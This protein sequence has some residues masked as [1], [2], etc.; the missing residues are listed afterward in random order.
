MRSLVVT[1]FLAALIVPALLPFLA[2]AQAPTSSNDALT[3]AQELF[4]NADFRS[5]AVAFQKIIATKPSAEAYSGL[6]RSL[7]KADDV[8]AADEGSQKALAALPESALTHIARGDVYFR[9]G[10]VPEAEAEYKTALNLDD[11]SSRGWL[12]QGK[13]DSIYSRR[14]KSKAA[15]TRAHELD[16]TDGDALYEWAIRQPYPENVAALENHLAEYHNDPDEERHEREYKDFVKALAGRN[17]WVPARAVER[18]VII[19]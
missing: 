19:M 9:R 7:L 5:A 6:V 8:I 12:G 16:P 15:I 14:S 1:R 2:L 13:V 3:D 18:T 10:M 17:V 4:R 11:K